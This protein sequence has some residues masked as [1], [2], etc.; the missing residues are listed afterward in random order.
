MPRRTFSLVSN[1]TTAFAAALLLFAAASAPAQTFISLASFDGTNGTSPQAPLVQAMDGNYY[2]TTYTG[3]SSELPNG[4]IF[5]INAAGAL[6]SVYSF[7]VT[8][9]C[10]DGEIPTA[11]MIL[12]TDGNLYGSTSYG[13]PN[14]GGTVFR[15]NTT[16]GVLTTIYNFCSLP[17]CRDGY[18]PNGLIQ[19]ADGSFYGT[20][21]YTFRSQSQGTVF[22]LTPTGVLTTLYTFCQQT[23]C[24]DG[25][26]PRAGVVQ[27]TDGNFY[28]TTYNGGNC[29]AGTVFKITPAGVF[30]S[31]H[32]FC[33]SDGTLPSGLL[34]VESGDL[35]GTTQ[36]YGANSAGTVFDITTGGTLTTLYNFCAETGCTDGSNP[37]L[38]S[39]LIQA[40]DGNIYGTT[41]GG[42]SSNNGTIFKMTPA[43][44]LTTLHSFDSSDG[45]G[46]VGALVQATAGNFY[47]TTSGGGT[48]GDGTVFALGTGL[49]AFAETVPTVGHVGTHVIILGNN[50]ASTTSVTFN[51]TPT[52]FTVVS[53]GAL[54]TTV[55]T[56]A[57]TGV[58]QVTTPIRTLN[59]NVS[60][61]VE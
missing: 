20:T 24:T 52:T 61:Q 21:S 25:W 2:G 8:T 56:A 45:A 47:G 40:T 14:G 12:A 19:A 55:P 53:P 3:G 9:S 16:T 37:N 33:Y 50:L 4:T 28:G 18:G 17:H 58:V 30:T 10:S 36:S 15:L 23:G 41:G 31:L 6:T 26:I 1:L 22:K 59:S 35:L 34:Q 44:A 32:S 39:A 51:G 49:G 7:C 57:T 38:Y 54:R 29:N 5:K 27:A 43:G 46:P 60:F 13:G 48:D 42:G 11:G